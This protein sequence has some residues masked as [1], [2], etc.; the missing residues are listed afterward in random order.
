LSHTYT[1]IGY[2]LTKAPFDDIRVRQALSYATPQ[3]QIIQS[4]LHGL[5]QIAT[6]PYKPNTFWYN[7]NVK[8]YDYDLDK[9]RELLAEAGFVLN[10][11]GVLERDGRPFRIELLTNQ[12]TT[13]TQIAEIVQSAWGEL[14]I[15][16]NIRVAEWGAFIKEFIERRNFDAAILAWNIVLDPDPTDV[17]HSRSCTDKKT[18]NFV[19]FQNAEADEL[20]EK[21]LLSF[22][23]NVRKRY[24]DRFQEILAEEAPYTFLYIP[25]ELVAISSRFRNIDPAPAG[26]THNQIHWYVPFAEQKYEVAQ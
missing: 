4:V 17:W 8:T 15:Q 20:M 6:G 11:R 3:E 26:F 21:A 23:P 19:C 16:V 7:G 2:N 24:Y 1:Y 13:R 22:D 25:Q 12:N 10:N 18:L 14:G 9:A 5:G